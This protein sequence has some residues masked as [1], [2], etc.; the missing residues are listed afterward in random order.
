[1]PS[2]ERSGIVRFSAQAGQKASALS[3]GT[4][5]LHSAWLELAQGFHRLPSAIAVTVPSAVSSA[6]SASLDGRK[7]SGRPQR[8]Q[9]VFSK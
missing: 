9:T 3:K 6:E 1:M 2:T 7:P 4:S 8:M 5:Q